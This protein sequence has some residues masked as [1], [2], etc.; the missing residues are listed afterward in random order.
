MMTRNDLKRIPEIRREMSRA[1]NLWENALESATR[2]TTVITGM[3]KGNTVNSQVETAVVKAETFKEKYDELC[4]ELS[5]IYKS[6]N[7]AMEKLDDQEEK[8][9][10][11]TYFLG[12]K[13]H[14][15]AT[16]MNITE[17]HVYRLKKTAISKICR[18]DFKP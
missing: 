8:V 4:E 2:T 7:L 6:L 14:E 11:K 9:I 16:E 12:K 15:I 17:R 3:P 13:V 10:T 1:L 5:K 18:L